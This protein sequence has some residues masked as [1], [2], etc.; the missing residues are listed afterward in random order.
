MPAEVTTRPPEL[1][2]SA[3]GRRAGR[4]GSSRPAELDLVVQERP[5]RQVDGTRLDDGFVE[6]HPTW[7]RNAAHPA[8]SP[9]RLG[10]APSRAGCPVSST[11]W[12]ASMSRSPAARTSQVHAHRGGPAGSSMWSKNGMP[13]P[14][15]GAAGAVQVEL[16]RD[17]R[18]RRC[19]A[20]PSLGPCGGAVVHPARLPQARTG[21]GVMFGPHH[22]RTWRMASRNASFSSGVAD[23]DPQA[24]RPTP[25]TRSSCAPTRSGRRAPATP[26]RPGRRR[27][28]SRRRPG[29]GTG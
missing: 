14:A 7:T 18:S 26:R 4:P 17:V 24:A 9:Q 5:T 27:T 28:A 29:A 10:A 13:G 16:D 1:L 12:C 25:A 11:V 15:L 22:P 19:G 23:G 3:A 20:T 8:L 6:R 21:S 2:A